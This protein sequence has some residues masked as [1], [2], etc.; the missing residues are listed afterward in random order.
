MNKSIFFTLGLFAILSLAFSI[1]SA[2]SYNSN[3]DLQ[4]YGVDANVNADVDVKNVQVNPDGTVKA[5]I[6]VKSNVQGNV[7]GQAVDTQNTA[8]Y[9]INAKAGEGAVI[10]GTIKD[11][12]GNIIA[13]ES[14]K[15]DFKDANAVKEGEKIALSNGKNAEIKVMP[16]TASATAIA[17]LSI[18]VCSADNNCTIQFKETGS[19]DNIKLA[20]EVKAD[21]NFKILGIFKSKKTISAEVDAETGEVIKTK[22]PWWSF[23]ASSSD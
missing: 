11:S 9:S 14:K 3:I 17:R 20:Y 22:G 2:Q 6:S 19:G 4:A 12:N 23:I 13:S 10:N 8:D 7:N 21:K 18:K 15:M 16:S 1:V 5:D